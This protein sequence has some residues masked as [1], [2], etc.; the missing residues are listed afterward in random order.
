[1][2]WYQASVWIKKAY[3]SVIISSCTLPSLQD[4]RWPRFPGHMLFL[5]PIE[6]GLSKSQTSFNLSP[7]TQL[8]KKESLWYFLDVSV[9]IISTRLLILICK[10]PTFNIFLF[11][12]SLLLTYYFSP[13][14]LCRGRSIRCRGGGCGVEIELRRTQLFIKLKLQLNIFIY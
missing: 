14:Y 8:Q 5:S 1:M 12:T 11:L 6:T 7:K 9:M 4:L 2:I 13:E 3:L 10:S